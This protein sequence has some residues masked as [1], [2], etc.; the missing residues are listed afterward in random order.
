MKEAQM[1]KSHTETLHFTIDGEWFTW[2]LRHLWVEGSEI[3]AIK[4]WNASF[5]QLSAVKYLKTFFLD[6]VSG[7][8]KFVGSNTFQLVNDGVKCWNPDQGG[9]PS[10]AFPLLNS[11]EDVVL[12]KKAKL[13]LAEIDLRAFRLNRKYGE[14]HE[15][16]HHSSL[17]WLSA[18]GENKVEND[19]RKKVNEYYTAIRNISNTAGLDL[20]VELI[21]EKANQLDTRVYYSKGIG[22]K[23][24]GDTGINNGLNLFY[25]I[26]RTVTPW[27]MYFKKKYGTDMLFI[28]EEY[29][30]EMCGCSTRKMEYYKMSREIPSDEEINNRIQGM[31]PG[32]TLDTYITGMLEESKRERIVSED[33]KK[34]KWTS[35]YIDREGE[36]FG[37]S[38]I[39]HLNFSKDICKLLK[40]KES[41]DE[42]F[43]AQIY[44]DKQGWVK[45][46]VNRFYWDEDQPVTQAQKDA[47]FDYMVAKEITT[48]IFNNFHGKYMTYK[49]ALGPE[50]GLER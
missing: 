4:T 7:K 10:K 1:K 34:T 38:D 3:K 30:K 50:D 43:D 12:L 26:M 5:P 28:N 27:D 24:S 37:C 25:Q 11:W 16:V 44:L 42:K 15:D 22:F 8:Q 45:V 13:Y 18:A 6:I 41:E 21:P 29:L 20:T 32:V 48:T 14:T 47:M 40:V 9:K 36:F 33:I 31:L 35:G 19:L 23:K 17:V 49:E 2:M 39:N 46:S